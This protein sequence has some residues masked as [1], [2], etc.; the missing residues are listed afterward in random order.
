M[1]ASRLMIDTADELLAV[2]DGQPARGHGG[3]AD[4]VAY[5]RSHGKPVHVIWPAGAERGQAGPGVLG[6]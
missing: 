4:V 5:A 3:T 6:L 1:A 2:W